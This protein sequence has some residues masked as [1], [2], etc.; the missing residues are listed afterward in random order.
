MHESHC[1]NVIQHLTLKCLGLV[2]FPTGQ[3]GTSQVVNCITNCTITW[4]DVKLGVTSASMNQWTLNIP[5]CLSRRGSKDASSC[6]TLNKLQTFAQINI[7]RMSGLTN[8]FLKDFSQKHSPVHPRKGMN[9]WCHYNRSYSGDCSSH[10]GLFVV[11]LHLHQFVC[12]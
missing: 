6:C 1:A 3:I 12:Q 9:S 7:K 10:I 11:P 8:R 5:R 4:M 2:W